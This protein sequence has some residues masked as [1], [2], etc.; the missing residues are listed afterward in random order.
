M[1]A[2]HTKFHPPTNTRIP[3]VSAKASAG[4][5]S[6]PW[7]DNLG[8]EENHERAARKLMAKFGWGNCLVGG[9]MPEGVGGLVW[10]MIPNN[11]PLIAACAKLE[12]IREEFQA[13]ARSGYHMGVIS[14][15]MDLAR[16]GRQ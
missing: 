15:A 14:S 6:I 3:R 13:G 9:S 8:I 4:R 16:E 7:A 10:V 1:Q 5:V 11:H 12:S 2:I